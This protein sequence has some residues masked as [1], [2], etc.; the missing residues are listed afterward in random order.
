MK[1]PFFA[2]SNSSFVTKDPERELLNRWLSMP[3]EKRKREFVGTARAAEIAGVSRR[4]IL[5]WIQAGLIFSVRIGKKHQVRLKSL[6][7]YLYV[8][9]SSDV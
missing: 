6:K 7:T 4:T 2:R 8:R 9:S 3:T 1:K 5:D